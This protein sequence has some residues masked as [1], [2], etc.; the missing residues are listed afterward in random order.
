MV[1]NVSP[2]PLLVKPAIWLPLTVHTLSGS[3]RKLSCFVHS[4][5]R[6]IASLPICATNNPSVFLSGIPGEKQRVDRQ[7]THPVA[8]VVCRADVDE[9]PDAAL[10]E[11]ANVVLRGEGEV[12]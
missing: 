9:R 3:F 6:V 11:G 2:P 5:A 8:D 10:E 12:I 4:R 7:G 1:A